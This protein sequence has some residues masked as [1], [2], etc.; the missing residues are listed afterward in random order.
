MNIFMAVRN[1][2]RNAT[3]SYILGDSK[4]KDY[5]DSVLGVSSSFAN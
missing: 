3:V 4:N 5:G 1:G 2:S